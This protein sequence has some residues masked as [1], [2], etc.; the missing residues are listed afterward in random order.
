MANIN[1]FDRLKKLFSTN[2][3]VRHIGGRKLKVA[4]TDMMQS[5]AMAYLKDKYTRLYST[6][7]LGHLNDS[8]MLAYQTVRLELFRDYDVMD[9]DPI[10]AS[11]LDIYADECCVSNEYGEILTIQSSNDDIKGILYNLFYDVLNIEFNL[12]SW[13][14]NMCKYGDFYLALDIVPEYGIHN[15]I[16]IST[17]DMKRI[18]NSDPKNPNYVYFEQESMG[19]DGKFENYQ[20]AHFRL[21]SDSNWLPYGRGMIEPARRIWKQ[22]SLMEDAMLIHRVMRAPEKRIYKIDI[23]NIPPN[24]VDNHMNKIMNKM[25]KTPFVDPQTG[26]YNLRFNLQNMVEDFYLP[27]RGSD[28]GTSIDTLSGMEFGGI[29]DIE[30]LRNKMLAALKIPKAFLNYD[31]SI[32]GK[33]VLSAEDLRFARTISRVQKILISELNK[34]AYVHLFTL[35][36]T[37][38]DLVNFSLQ[39]TTPSSIF[40]QEKIT[41]WGDKVTLAKDIMDNKLFSRK[42]IYQN[43]FNLS[44]DDI[45]ADREQLVSDQK[46]TYRMK[47]IEEEGKDPAEGE[48]EES[49][50]GEEPTGGEK[51][52]E[53]PGKEAGEELPPPLGEN[54]NKDMPTPEEYEEWGKEGGEEGGGRPKVSGTTSEK[55]EKH[56]GRDRL[57]NIENSKRTNSQGEVVPSLRKKVEVKTKKTKSMALQLEEL[58]DYLKNFDKKLLKEETAN[59]PP[60]QNE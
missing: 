47:Q 57:G 11:A 54:L 29:D 39:L 35:G 1:I 56:W 25:K 38:E 2:V 4:D 30:Y 27:V 40:E 41:L 33:A 37:N 49:G 9:K 42:W 55:R 23:G 43:V 8:N 21:L 10:I 13:T 31:E 58:D 44:G 28:S 19:R 59:P 15:V 46:E 24:E 14:R 48:S 3:V 6:S 51:E 36:Y 60:E 34:I 18:E 17:Y 53:A 12:W 5:S 20:V 45:E 50:G 26:D 32:S 52:G 16:P 22:L 7:Y